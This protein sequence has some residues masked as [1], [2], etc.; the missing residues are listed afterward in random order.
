MISAPRRLPLSIGSATVV[1]SALAR[2]HGSDLLPLRLHFAHKPAVCFEHRRRF[3][4]WQALPLPFAFRRVRSFCPP[5][6][7]FNVAD[8]FETGRAAR[9]V[10]AHSSNRLPSGVTAIRP[11]FRN[12][13]RLLDSARN[14]FTFLTAQFLFA[15]L[16]SARTLP[17]ELVNYASAS[18]RA[19][20]L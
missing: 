11:S 3:G 15:L 8:S 9:S 10:L 13:L 12:Q 14:G 1:D 18:S 6:G 5:F 16:D 20:E 17:E 2:C 7:V 4:S 19:A